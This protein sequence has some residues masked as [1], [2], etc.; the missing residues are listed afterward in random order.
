VGDASDRVLKHETEAKIVEI[1]SFQEDGHSK[2]GPWGYHPYPAR[3]LSRDQ[4]RNK[5]TEMQMYWLTRL[6]NIRGLVS[7]PFNIFWVLGFIVCTVFVIISRI[8][9][10]PFK[11]PLWP[12]FFLLGIMLLEGVVYAFLPTTKEMAAILIVP[13]IV[14]NQKVQEMPDK[15]LDLANDWLEKLKPTK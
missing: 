4:R 15:V 7:G 13:R 3:F 2:A 5:M 10:A 8:E 9:E 14:N 11:M 1:A 12:S 6:D